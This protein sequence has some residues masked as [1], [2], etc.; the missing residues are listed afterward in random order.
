MTPPIFAAFPS[1]SHA[2]RAVGAL[3]DHGARAD[4]MTLS[5]QLQPALLKDLEAR[6]KLGLS[7]TTLQDT[8]RGGARGALRGAFLGA[9]IVGTA[10]WLPAT[11]IMP[12]IGVVLLAFTAAGFFVG[13]LWGALVD[14][15]AQ[16][17]AGVAP[18]SLRETPVRVKLETPL[19]DISAKAAEHLMLKYGAFRVGQEQ[20]PAS[21]FFGPYGNSV[22]VGTIIES[23][24]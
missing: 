14:Q 1:G 15:G 19:S 23:T 2:I 5:A 9:F 22:R 6:A 16:C 11:D 8:W 13:L 20:L 21:G 17:Q 12:P 4:Q 18:W 24:A 3:I 10:R 7:L